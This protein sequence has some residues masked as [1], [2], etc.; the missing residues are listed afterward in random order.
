MPNQARKDQRSSGR[1]GDVLRV[2]TTAVR[3]LPITDIAGRLGLHPNTV[4]FHLET[5]VENG[6]AERVT[7]VHRAPG[8]PPQL[9]R[10]TR[11]MDPTGPRH[12]RLLAEV[13][14]DALDAE[15]DP[16]DRAVRAGRAWG[17]RHGT[18]DGDRPT[19]GEPLVRLVTLLDELGFAPE[20]D[21]P[22]G[23]APQIRLR[24]CPFLEL[25][26]SRPQIACPIHLGMMQGA[27]A[28]WGSP[29][30]VDRLVAFAEPDVCVAHLAETGS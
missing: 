16:R 4:R 25:A 14:A 22:P 27:M 12:Y 21:E 8:R 10:A 1:R 15:P 11:G 30:T 18:K 3:P 9:F 6:Q 13:L 7:P 24:N 20:R 19:G 26:S 23:E 2:L 17:R 5:L 29:T 28:A